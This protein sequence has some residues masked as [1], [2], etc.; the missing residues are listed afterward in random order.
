[1]KKCFKKLILK[2]NRTRTS[3]NVFFFLCMTVLL[4]IIM[5]FIVVLNYRGVTYDV[6]Q[7]PANISATFYN[8]LSPF[9]AIV[10]AALTFIAF[11]TQYKANQ[12]M[13][14]SYEDQRKN[15]AKQEFEHQF[16]EMLRIHKENVKE[17]K[18]DRWSIVGSSNPKY[19]CED[20]SIKKGKFFYNNK[21]AFK[22]VMG[23]EVFEYYLVE[24][25]FIED[26]LKDAIRIVCRKNF[27]ARNKDD[28][29][30]LLVFAYKIFFEGDRM[31]ED[32][33]GLQTTFFF[34]ACDR[35]IETMKKI[36]KKNGRFIFK[37]KKFVLTKKEYLFNDYNGY[38]YLYLYYFLSVCKSSYVPYS[39]KSGLHRGFSGSEN[40]F[41]G[42]AYELNHY[43]RHLFQMVK[44]VANYNDSIVEKSEKK[45]YLRMLRAQ[46]TNVE[47]LML[48][49]NWLSGYGDDWENDKNHF[50]TEFR[51]IHNIILEDCNYFNVVGYEKI[52]RMIKHKNSAYR[53]YEDGCLFEFEEAKLK[54]VTCIYGEKIKGRGP[55]VYADLVPKELRKVLGFN[56]CIKAEKYALAKYRKRIPS[57]GM[58]K[59]DYK[60]AVED[61]QNYIKQM[62]VW[63][64]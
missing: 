27:N 47:Q 43:Y 54:K 42:H 19:V 30:T 40:L 49:Y 33:F 20:D 41:G 3:N 61:I 11:W 34:N 48:F 63:E 5:T 35:R 26:C 10:A 16:Y 32:Y 1:M 9:I 17:L 64:D 38:I 62:F 57:T 18:W 58:L 55:F 2:I 60:L 56:R 6:F 28:Y 37:S 53:D 59:D 8:V 25:F 12:E 24:F 45:K 31:L 14:K 7:S 36:F 15:N 50:F 23:R 44:I 39:F 13:F 51:M 22:P 21:Y 52:V 4:S 29:K 46:L